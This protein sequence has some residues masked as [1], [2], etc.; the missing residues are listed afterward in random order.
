MIAKRACE[1]WAQDKRFS[2]TFEIKANVYKAEWIKYLQ[3]GLIF[4]DS[5]GLVDPSDTVGVNAER[6]L[7]CL[8]GWD[9]G[10]ALT[11]SQEQQGP[12]RASLF[13]GRVSEGPLGR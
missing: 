13:W 12:A 10:P 2:Q 1:T 9:P 3:N 4:R 5:E 8:R 6:G 11:S 7:A